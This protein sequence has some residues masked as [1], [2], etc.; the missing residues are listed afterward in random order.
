MTTRD[1]TTKVKKSTL[2]REAILQN[3]LEIFDRQVFANTS[4]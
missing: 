4:L 2:R 3:A 1:Q